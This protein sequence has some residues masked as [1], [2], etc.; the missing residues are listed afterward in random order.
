LA[1]SATDMDASSWRMARI[2]RSVESIS[3]SHRY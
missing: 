1:I 2:L 3:Q